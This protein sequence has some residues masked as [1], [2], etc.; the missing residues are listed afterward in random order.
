MKTVTFFSYKG[1][2]GRTLT[3]ANFAVY[4]TKLGLNVVIMDFDL[5]APGVDSKFPEFSLPKGQLGLIDYVLRFQRNGSPPGPIKDIY[6]KIP[7]KSLRQEYVL[8]LIPA[9]DYLAADYP[10]KLNELSWSLIFSSQ[11]DG[12]AFF[13]LFLEQ[14][15]KELKPDVLIIDSRTGFSEIGGLCTQQLADETVILSSLARESVKMTRHL[16]QVIR[17]SEISKQL[18][19]TVETKIVVCRV[20]NPGARDIDKLKAQCCKKFDVD[21]TRLFFLFSCAGL[22]QDEFVAMMDTRKE[23]S[24]VSNY[25]KLFQGLNVEVAYKTIREEIERTERGLL[26][27]TTEEADARIRE[28][29]AL[30]PDAEVYRRAMRFFNLRQRPDE[31]SVIALRLLD[32]LPDDSEANLQVARLLFEARIF[33]VEGRYIHF[34][35]PAF[36]GRAPQVLLENLDAYRVMTIAEHAYQT[37]M[38]GIREKIRMADL[39][40]DLGKH[41]RSFELAKECIN[42]GELEDAEMRG[43]ALG[44]AARSAMR[45]GKKDEAAKLVSEIPISQLR[46]GL[47]SIAVQQRLET[48][49]AK[50]AFELAKIILAR[51]LDSQIIKV[52]FELAQQLGQRKE[53]EDIIRT[54][55][56][57]KKGRIDDPEVLTMLQRCGFDVSE[58]WDRS[59][60][61]RR[62][63]RPVTRE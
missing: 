31:A 40:E 16:A 39:M 10:G 37:G 24:L 57:L 27:C 9:G 56:D 51:G 20:P 7:I 49:D 14:I 61:G 45:I 15:E 33:S 48:G 22:E 47:A 18:K 32:L 63:R 2:N 35:H 41:E 26:S 3:A 13:Q 28:M 50:A 52:A 25:V 46:G 60:A 62:V 54:H 34:S 30:Y 4:L 12:V 59:F 23:E 21:E 5:D 58:Y 55:P 53:F 1:G 11:R 6:C 43:N 17:E 19:K 36:G 38:L 8:G 44:I 29:V 42:S